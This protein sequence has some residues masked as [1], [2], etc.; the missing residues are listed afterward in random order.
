M[1]DNLVFVDTLIAL[2]KLLNRKGRHQ[3]ART[4][5]EWISKDGSFAIKVNDDMS[6]QILKD[7]EVTNTNH[8]MDKWYDTAGQV[9]T[10]IQNDI[11][12]G[13]YPKLAGIKGELVKA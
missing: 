9:A 8:A 10:H 3:M 12:F 5:K 13:Y 4:V 11:D 6:Y 1:L 7:G 2:R